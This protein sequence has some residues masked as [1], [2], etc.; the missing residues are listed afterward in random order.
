MQENLVTNTRKAKDLHYIYVG[1]ILVDIFIFT[2]IQAENIN[3]HDVTRF[4]TML[5]YVNDLADII[6]L[7]HTVRF[8]NLLLCHQFC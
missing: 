2:K 7:M 1:K 8:S 4:V 3:L 6:T 5:V